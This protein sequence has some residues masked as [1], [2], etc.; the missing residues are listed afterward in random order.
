MESTNMYINS[1]RLFHC[2]QIQNKTTTEEDSL[3]RLSSSKLN[4][5][6]ILNDIDYLIRLNWQQ[7]QSVD[8]IPNIKKVNIMFY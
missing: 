6:H 5:G 2:P 4:M 7:L 1:L 8:V 3:Q